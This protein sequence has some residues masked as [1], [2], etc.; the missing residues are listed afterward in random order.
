M[1]N[2]TNF[3]YGQQTKA[4]YALLSGVDGPLDESFGIG[5]PIGKSGKIRCP[6]RGSNFASPR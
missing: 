4:K 1:C 6:N 3:C 5:I 2:V